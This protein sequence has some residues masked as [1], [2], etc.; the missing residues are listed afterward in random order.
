[1]PDP[2]NPF[3]WERGGLTD[4]AIA[5]RAA[6]HRQAMR[7]DDRRRRVGARLATGTLVVLTVVPAVWAIV[8]GDWLQAVVFVLLAVLAYFCGRGRAAGGGSVLYGL[9]LGACLLWLVVTGLAMPSA[10]GAVALLG[11]AVVIVWI[12]AFVLA[13]E[14]RRRAVL[15]A[16][17]PFRWS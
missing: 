10:G 14:L 16:P 4:A 6:A 2:V 7:D 15:R 11:L 1:M 8:V 9:Y 5:E 13:V 17:V 12:I 3:P